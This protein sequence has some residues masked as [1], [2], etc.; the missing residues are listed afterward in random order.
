MSRNRKKTPKTLQSIRKHHMK[1]A[2]GDRDGFSQG[3]GGGGEGKAARGDR[4]RLSQS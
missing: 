1:A 3:L 4:D 2:R